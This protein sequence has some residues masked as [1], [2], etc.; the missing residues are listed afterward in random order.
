M[1]LPR[2]SRP[3]AA[4]SRAPRDVRSGRVAQGPAM[5][6]ARRLRLLHIWLCSRVVPNSAGGGGTLARSPLT[7]AKYSS[8]SCGRGCCAIG[9]ARLRGS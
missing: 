3:G 6:S 5:R 8:W 4:P 1:L 7:A 2:Q 9:C